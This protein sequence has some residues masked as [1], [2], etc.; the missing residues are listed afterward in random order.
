MRLHRLRYL[1][2]LLAGLA[3][4]HR[5]RVLHRDLKPQN[6][7]INRRGVLQLADFGLARTC[8]WPHTV[9]MTH[10]VATLWYRAPEVLLGAKSYTESM[11]MWAVG[12]IFA[13]MSSDL[14]IFAGDSEIA[15]LFKIFQSAPPRHHHDTTTQ[16]HHTTHSVHP[17]SHDLLLPCVR[18]SG[19][20][21]GTPS[22]TT[23]P[24][25]TGL[26]D[27]HSTFPSWRPLTPSALQL[28]FPALD[29]LGVDLLQRFLTLDP[30]RRCSAD[31]ALSHPYFQDLDVNWARALSE[32]AAIQ[33]DF[34]DGTERRR[35]RHAR[36]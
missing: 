13:E 25:V 30:S 31:H 16:P 24:G 19:R 29:V 32:K 27:F 3:H 21:T 33:L 10:D 23:W 36:R 20:F 6:L 4:C 26:N 9:T 18:V 7:L 14:P 17:S 34:N 1:Q 15:T 5:H 35:R 28:R 22:D 2:Q 12:C 11:D 8:A